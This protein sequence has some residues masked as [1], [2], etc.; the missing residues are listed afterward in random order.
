MVSAICGK[1]EFLTAYTP[2]Q[3]EASQGMLQAIFEFQSAI[4]A[5]TGMDVSN[6]SL[7]D[8]ASACAEAVL[9]ALR[10][11]KERN[12]VILATNLHPHYRAVVQQYLSSHSISIVLAPLLKNGNLDLKKLS[13]LIDDQTAGGFLSLLSQFLWCN[14]RFKNG[15]P[16]GK[17]KTGLDNTYAP[18]PW[19]MAFMLLLEK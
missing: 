14:R 2:Y 16:S 10:H 3:P 7:Y 15:Q 5:L 8:G 12:K 13:D 17:I 18:I 1:S 4:C 19:F 11:H 6:A 9:M